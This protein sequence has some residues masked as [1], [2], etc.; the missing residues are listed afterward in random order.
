MG[1]YTKKTC[2]ICGL[3][4]IQPNMVRASKNVKVGSS[5]QAVTAGTWFWAAAGSKSAEN[6]VKKVFTANNK[7]SYTRKREVWMC[8]DCANDNDD[9]PGLLIKII[10]TI[11]MTI[12]TVVV[13]I[14]ALAVLGAV[15]GG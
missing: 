3:R 10:S 5:K 11:F 4:D 14:V 8:G 15:L 6:R 2:N 9:E 7:R 1:E 13:G 12:I